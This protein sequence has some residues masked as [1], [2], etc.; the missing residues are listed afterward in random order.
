MD[1]NK[2][3]KLKARYLRIRIIEKGKRVVWLP[4]IPLSFLSV[5]ARVGLKLGLKIAAMD[6]ENKDLKQVVPMLEEFNAKEVFD[7]LMNL[8]PFV[9]VE[10]Y[11]KED[12]TEV[13]ICTE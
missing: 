12:Q 1:L 4:K 7:A 3:E 11:S 2:E 10:V 8:E 13:L 5:L 6:Q 9:L